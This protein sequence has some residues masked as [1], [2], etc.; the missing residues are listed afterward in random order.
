M[1][2]LHLGKEMTEEDLTNI[3]KILSG[4]EDVAAQCL[5]FQLK[6][7]KAWDEPSR[8]SFAPRLRYGTCCQLLVYFQG[9]LHAGSFYICSHLL[10]RSLGQGSLTCALGTP[11]GITSVGKSRN[12][13]I[14]TDDKPSLL[15]QTVSIP[16]QRAFFKIWTWKPGDLCAQKMND[17]DNPKGTNKSLHVKAWQQSTPHVY[18]SFAIPSVIMNTGS[19]W[20][21]T[22]TKLFNST[23][24]HKS[25]RKHFFLF[26]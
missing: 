20:M 21:L 4:R 16:F 12:I 23:S 22:S 11:A 13:L 14:D 7:W 25:A 6:S 15:I 3:F 8:E 1:R 9:F 17:Q 10:P 2:T 18:Y 19:I 5:Y 24:P 26:S